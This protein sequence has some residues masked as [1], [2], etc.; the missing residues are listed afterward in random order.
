MAPRKTS[1][2]R[3][4][5]YSANWGSML[6]AAE[7]YWKAEAYCWVLRCTSPRLNEVFHSNGLR[8]RACLRPVDANRANEEKTLETSPY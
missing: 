5:P 8:Y 4:L 3:V 2:R 1:S 6:T 7:R